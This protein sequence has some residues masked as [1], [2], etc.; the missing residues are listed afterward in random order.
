MFI[1][2][3]CVFLIDIGI[4]ELV[5]VEF[6]CIMVYQ[7]IFDVSLEELKVVGFGLNYV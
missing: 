7:L 5:Y 2:N 4:E 6:I 3:M 1:G